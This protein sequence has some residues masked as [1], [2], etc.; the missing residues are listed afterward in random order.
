MNKYSTHDSSSTSERYCLTARPNRLS[1]TL[2][3]LFGLSC[4]SALTPSMA[5]TFTVNTTEDEIVANGKCSLREAL[6]NAGS[7]STIF[8]DCPA[9]SG[10][11]TIVFDPSVFPPNTLTAISLVSGTQISGDAGAGL[12]I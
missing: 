11:D 8:A 12:G 5:T 9:G 6:A 3:A 1:A 4:V 7:N 2:R 10:A